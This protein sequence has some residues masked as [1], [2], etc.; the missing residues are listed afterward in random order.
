MKLNQPT[1]HRT[2]ELRD[3]ILQG[4]I[5]CGKELKNFND[6]KN[7]IDGGVITANEMRWCQE[8]FFTYSETDVVLR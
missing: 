2:L 3:I 6:W 4:V 5:E 7:L 8:N 1:E